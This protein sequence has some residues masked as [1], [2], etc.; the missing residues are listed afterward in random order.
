MLTIKELYKYIVHVKLR[1]N[2][3]SHSIHKGKNN[4]K[5]NIIGML[6]MRNEALILKDTLDHLSTIVDGIVIYD[7]CSTD[8]SV[9]IALNHPLVLKVCKNASWRPEG[10]AWEESASRQKLYQMARRYKPIWIMYSDADERFEGDIRGYL[11]SSN[12]EGVDGIRISLYDAYMTHSDH[13]PFKKGSKL[14]NFRKYFGKEKRDILMIWRNNSRVYF[15]RPDARE[16]VGV[17][18]IETKFLC[19]H[20]GKSISVEQWEETCDY[21]SKYFPQYS[22]KWRNRKGKAVHSKSDFNTD[23]ITWDTIQALHM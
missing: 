14:Y 17:K 6:R 8:D 19:Q 21:Y 13:K 10:R 22:E 15:N 1:N 16:P 18:N 4:S 9:K 12:S 7:D 11:L 2:P 3:L 23:L 5:I 20:Y